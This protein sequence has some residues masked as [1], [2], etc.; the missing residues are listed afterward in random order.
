MQVA[1]GLF[2]F[3][4]S[5]PV[6]ENLTVSLVKVYF[7][8]NISNYALYRSYVFA[9]CKHQG[10]VLHYRLTREVLVSGK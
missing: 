4:F 5:L 1:E 8:R 2:H 9:L 7:L 3:D 10:T 6:Y